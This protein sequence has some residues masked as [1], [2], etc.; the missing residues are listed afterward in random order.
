[1]AGIYRLL[2]HQTILG[3]AIFCPFRRDIH[4]RRPSDSLNVN[5]LNLTV[6]NIA[7]LFR[8]SILRR[9]SVGKSPHSF[10]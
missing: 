5:H 6:K 9:E 4:C 7:S 2:V 8:L 3:L 10:L 1:M